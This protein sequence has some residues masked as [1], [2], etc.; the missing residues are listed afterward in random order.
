MSQPQAMEPSEAQVPHSDLPGRDHAATYVEQ[1]LEWWREQQFH[2]L[3]FR[4][5]PE[6]K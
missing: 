2:H 3:G 6:W 1:Q 4:L 5:E